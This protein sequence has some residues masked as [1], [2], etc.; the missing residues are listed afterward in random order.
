MNFFCIVYNDTK[1]AQEQATWNNFFVSEN[2]TSQRFYAL[3]IHGD[4]A[5]VSHDTFTFFGC[6]NPLPPVDYT[7]IDSEYIRYMFDHQKDLEHWNSL[8][9][10]LENIGTDLLR[11]II[12]HQLPLEAL[13]REI[14]KQHCIDYEGKSCSEEEAKKLWIQKST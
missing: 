8:I 3:N 10:D 12:L 7:A 14:L 6:R 9:N 2:D 5:L 13:I 4:E 11:F 1:L